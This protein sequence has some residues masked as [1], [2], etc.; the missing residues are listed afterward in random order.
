MRLTHVH[1]CETYSH[2]T[3]QTACALVN[4]FSLVICYFITIFFC[5]Q[6]YNYCNATLRCSAAIYYAALSLSLLH[7]ITLYYSCPPPLL[8]LRSFYLR[9]TSLEVTLF[10]SLPLWK[11]RLPK[12]KN[13]KFFYY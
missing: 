1:I 3:N 5:L 4:N 13:K 10:Y 12:I 7:C 11:W 6:A 9:S 2:V 8:I